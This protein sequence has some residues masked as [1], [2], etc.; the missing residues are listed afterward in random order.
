MPNEKKTIRIDLTDE[1]QAQVKNQSG[2]ELPSVE[3]TVDE[4][5]ERIAPES[6]GFT[7]SSISWTYQR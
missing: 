7:Y 4:L 3:L 5:E 1:Q 6:V 2:I